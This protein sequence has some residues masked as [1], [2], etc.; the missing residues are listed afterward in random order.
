MEPAPPRLARLTVLAVV[1]GTALCSLLARVGADSRW[2]A[3][4]G[5]AV[6]HTG[7]VTTRIPY[8]ATPAH[9][10]NVPVLGELIFH[11]LEATA[12]D[13]GLVLAQLLTVALALSLL[14]IDMRAARTPDAA[15][16]VVLIATVF[17][18]A[19]ALIVVRSQ[20]FSLALF[21]ALLVLLR[22]EARLPSPRIWLLVPLVALWSNLHGA[23]LIGVFVILAYLLLHRLRQQP[24]VS[25][26][27]AAALVGALFATPALLRTAGYYA[28]VLTGEAARRGEGMWAPL[29]PHALFDV[30]FVIVAVPLAVLAAR[31]RP[32][33]WECVALAGLAAAAVH[34]NRNTVWFAF[35]VA[36]PAARRLG[37][38]RL[39]LVG[40]RRPIFALCLAASACVLA[41]GVLQPPI[42]VNAGDR[43]IRVTEAAAKGRPVLADELDAERLLI[44]GQRVW[45]ANPLDAFPANA[46]REYL[47]WLDGNPAGDSLRAR[48]AGVILV[49]RRSPAHNRLAGDPA[50][51]EIAADRYAVLYVRR[52]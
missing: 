18:A 4:M 38:G 48:V 32:A 25:C 50:F 33:L 11:A 44:A 26:A 2:L 29:S 52:P 8:A 35:F 1:L 40:M 17:S 7:A 36:G 15:A 51:R 21:P 19:P 16:A 47:D 10:T 30:V 43:L 13:R 22:R 27:V 24:L 37:Q 5:R 23:V 20:L 6:V 39:S 49:L 14:A 31:S 46:Q 12:G 42:E 41:A 28:G 34:A 9:W 3:V 45:I